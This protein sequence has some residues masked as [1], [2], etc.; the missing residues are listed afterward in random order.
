M[1]KPLFCSYA[2]LLMLFALPGCNKLAPARVGAPATQS[3]VKELSTARNALLQASHIARQS[4]ADAQ[5]ISVE[6][7]WIDAA[8]CSSEWSFRF[9]SASKRQQLMIEK[10]AIVLVESVNEP[11]PAMLNLDQW[12]FDSDAAVILLGLSHQLGFP[13]ASM[14]LGSDL[15]WQLKGPSGNQSLNARGWLP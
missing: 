12:R 13:I 15:L 1:V 4:S 2:A 8:G 14:K 7:R 6:G 3:G 10:G 5:L 9:L 11:L